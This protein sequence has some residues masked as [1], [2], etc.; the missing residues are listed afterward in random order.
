MVKGSFLG[1]YGA[2]NLLTCSGH[3]LIDVWLDMKVMDI[4]FLGNF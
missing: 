2:T 4:L 1:P 3:I